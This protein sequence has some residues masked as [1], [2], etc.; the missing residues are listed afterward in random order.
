MVQK[1]TGKEVGID[2]G[3]A[4]GTATFLPAPELMPFRFTPQ[5]IDLLQPLGTEGNFNL[6]SGSFFTK[7]VGCWEFIL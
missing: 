4:F 2:F 3:F 7:N 5:Y 1:T 6:E